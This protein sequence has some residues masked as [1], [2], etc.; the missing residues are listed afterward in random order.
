MILSR[1]GVVIDVVWIGWLDLLT[2]YAHHME[3]QVITAM[4]LIYTLYSSPL[5]TH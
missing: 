2:T 5:Q 3:L 1:V 4:S